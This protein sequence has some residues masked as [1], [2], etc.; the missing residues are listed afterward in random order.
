[1]S[2]RVFYQ[3]LDEHTFRPTP[4]VQG[5][6]NDDEQHMSPV[7]GLLAHALDRHEP[8]P[9][10]QL[11]R[12][13]YDI[14]GVIPLD[15]SVVATRT[16]RGGRTVELVEA[17]L[18]SRGRTAVRATAWRLSRQD[19]AAVAGGEP[20]ALPPVGALTRWEGAGIWGG[21]YI[22]ALEFHRH[23]DPEPGRGQVWLRSDVALV[24]GEPVSPAASFLRLVDTANGIATRVSPGE[25]MF[26]NVDLTVHLFREPC[27]DWVG[28]DTS[29]VFGATGLGVTSSWLHDERG[30]V[31]RA[32]QSLTVRPLRRRA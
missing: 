13:S 21:G 5:A 12:I 17:T 24:D 15:D 18:E 4:A 30:P 6:W 32:E 3:R 16:L 10:L 2:D 20:P 11:S 8:R 28:F 25:W 29:V 27:G 22:G 26:P 9:D 14:L 1:V 19:T 31:G 7:A 23:A